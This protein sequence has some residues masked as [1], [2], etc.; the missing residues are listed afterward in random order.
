MAK[1]K[2]QG[3][4]ILEV[5]DFR[6]SK[7]IPI[8]NR[9]GD[10]WMVEIY[11]KSNQDYDPDKPE[12]CA[13]PLEAFDTGIPAVEGDER[14]TKKVASCYAWLRK[15]RDKYSLDDIEDRKPLVAKINAAN[16]ALAK[17]GAST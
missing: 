7:A 8:I 13:M 17:L 10:T 2:Y 6:L 11:S 15:V 1:L 16:Q 9:S 12:T 3:V 4:N 5:W 14:D